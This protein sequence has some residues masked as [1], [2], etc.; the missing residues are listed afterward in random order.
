MIQSLPFGSS[1]TAPNH[2]TTDTMI[3]LG[4][5]E[6]V[7]PAVDNTNKG[8]SCALIYDAR[9][10][11]TSLGMMVRSTKEWPTALVSRRDPRPRDQTEGPL[12]SMSL[13]AQ[14]SS[15]R[16]IRLTGRLFGLARSRQLSAVSAFETV[17]GFR[18]GRISGSS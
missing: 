8:I 12:I 17:G 9:P 15:S 18:V 5:A 14:R 4:L 11:C 16:R 1:Q 3:S 10:L 2:L 7:M 6:H 13:K